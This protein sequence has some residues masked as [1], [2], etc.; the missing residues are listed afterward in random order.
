MK[1]YDSYTQWVQ[2]RRIESAREF[3]E[4]TGRDRYEA[5]S[6]GDTAGHLFGYAA[7]L[8]WKD[9]GP[10]FTDWIQFLSDLAGVDAVIAPGRDAA[11]SSV[12]VQ[13]QGLNLDYYDTERLFAALELMHLIEMRD[14]AGKTT[15]RRGKK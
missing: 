12:N 13:W 11:R 9:E 3:I 7:A 10:K 1:I 2:Q 4:S 15:K 5:D 8:G 14:K 6:H